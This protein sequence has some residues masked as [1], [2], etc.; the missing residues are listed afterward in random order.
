MLNIYF[1]DKASDYSLLV[2]FSI[3]LLS[4]QLSYNMW[5]LGLPPWTQFVAWVNSRDFGDD[6]KVMK[7]IIETISML[8]VTLLEAKHSDSY[9][10]ISQNKTGI[11]DSYY[12]LQS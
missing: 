4:V 10:P 6:N 5:L 7:E 9:H 11:I 12:H 3:S 2:G 1:R 8:D